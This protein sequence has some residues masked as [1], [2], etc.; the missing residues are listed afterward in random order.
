[1]KG[2]KTEKRGYGSK[3]EE[4]EWGG[5]T[6]PNSW[7][8]GEREYKKG[9]LKSDLVQQYSWGCPTRND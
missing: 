8:R 6:G 1:M 4:G 2:T 5:E 3:M 7:K 9:G